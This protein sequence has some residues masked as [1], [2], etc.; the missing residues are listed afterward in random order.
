[1]KRNLLTLITILSIAAPAWS[2]GVVMATQEDLAAFDSMI[3]EDRTRKEAQ[4]KKETA[5][6]NGNFNLIVVALN[7]N[8]K[9]IEEK[10]TNFNINTRSKEYSSDY[11]ERKEYFKKAGIDFNEIYVSEEV[12]KDVMEFGKRVVPCV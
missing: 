11:L 10:S 6:N 12:E 1:M 8:T 5:P 7:R 3:K 4:L 2:D 9:L